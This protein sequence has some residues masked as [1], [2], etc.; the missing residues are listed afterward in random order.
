MAGV[1]FGTLCPDT[2][3]PALVLVVACY[4]TLRFLEVLSHKETRS[5][6]QV[7]AGLLLALSFVSCSVATFGG[8]SSSPAAL[9]NP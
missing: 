3:I 4:T 6:I 9:S 5:A 8:A 7:A 1:S 2:M